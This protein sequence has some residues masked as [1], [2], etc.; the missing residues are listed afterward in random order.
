MKRSPP[1]H[2]LLVIAVHLITAMAVLTLVSAAENMGTFKKSLSCLPFPFTIPFFASAV[3][4]VG[5]SKHGGT[6]G[7]L[8]HIVDP[9]GNEPSDA[10]SFRDT[11]DEQLTGED[12]SVQRLRQSHHQRRHYRCL[13]F[14]GGERGSQGSMTA[15]STSI[16]NEASARNITMLH[17]DSAGTCTKNLTDRND[18]PIIP[19]V[20]YF[21][22][23]MKMKE[24]A[25]RAA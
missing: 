11:N 23:S 22:F 4:G 16:A 13:R 15:S 25:R 12:P 24:T 5:G 3:L 14:R 18:F 9:Y 8:Y 10:F 6:E 19:A 7:S 1:A 2:S 17:C 20:S 21:P